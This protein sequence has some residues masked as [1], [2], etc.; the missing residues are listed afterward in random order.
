MKNEKSSKV[1]PEISIIVCVAKNRGIGKKGKL[2][3]D[4]PADLQHFKRITMG[5]PIIMGYNT[6]KS[7][8]R[9]LPGRLNIVLS[10]DDIKI[11]GCKVAKNIPDA[12]KL[13]SENNSEEIFF[14]GGGMVYA[15]AIEFADR[16]YLTI[17][18]EKPE[19]DTFF[20]DYSKF[21]KIISEEAEESSGYKYKYVI[22]QKE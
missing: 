13:A 15:S 16:L 9:P 6:Y 7:I 12:I 4:I 2:L 18:D 22:L 19:A 17:V 20:P 11:D 10:P 21:Q 14:I 8:G 1:K 3:F 5:H